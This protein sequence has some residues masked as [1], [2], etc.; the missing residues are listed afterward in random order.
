[1]SV[2]CQLRSVARSREGDGSI[3]FRITRSRAWRR[4]LAI[5]FGSRG[6]G[7]AAGEEERRSGVPQSF[8]R[9]RRLPGPIGQGSVPGS[10]S[11]PIP[12]SCMLSSLLAMHISFRAMHPPSMPG[13]S[14]AKGA[15][16]GVWAQLVHVAL[17]LLL[18]PSVRIGMSTILCI[19]VHGL[20]GRAQLSFTYSA[21]CPPPFVRANIALSAYIHIHLNLSDQTRTRDTDI[22]LPAQQPIRTIAMY[23]TKEA[24]AGMR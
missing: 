11:C 16:V 22:L 24:A 9:G 2:H 6:R 13:T 10:L 3:Q 7:V 4:G 8:D 20:R 23:C 12:M 5:Q 18:S 19:H 17:V 21:I 14:H 15:A 1:M